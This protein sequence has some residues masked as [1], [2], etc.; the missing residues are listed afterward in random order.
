ML[1][2]DCGW[3]LHTTRI[4]VNAVVTAVTLASEVRAIRV[5][6]AMSTE[7]NRP[8]GKGRS[9]AEIDEVASTRP[10]SPLL[11]VVTFDSI[12]AKQRRKREN[13]MDGIGR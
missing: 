1:E 12:V 2:C 11:L 4:D 10:L 3:L 7:T 9:D 6:M 5:R 13:E 8:D